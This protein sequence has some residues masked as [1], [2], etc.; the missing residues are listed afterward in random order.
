MKY[1]RIEV[2][3]QQVMG[4]EG[5]RQF[6]KVQKNGCLFS[7]RS[8]SLGRPFS[9]A[10]EQPRKS[11][12]VSLTISVCSMSFLLTIAV[13]CGASTIEKGHPEND[14]GGV[15]GSRAVPGTMRKKQGIFL[16]GRV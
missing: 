16:A 8:E 5:I 2:Y 14:P 11:L 1:L 13:I 15:G 7:I 10:I 6:C 3:R 12:K 4:F 9:T